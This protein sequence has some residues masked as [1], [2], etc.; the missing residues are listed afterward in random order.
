E[1]QKGPAGGKHPGTAQ[2]QVR[3]GEGPDT[4]E[5]RGNFPHAFSHAGVLSSGLRLLKAQRRHAANS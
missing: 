4:G 3:S 2:D 1:G 5:F